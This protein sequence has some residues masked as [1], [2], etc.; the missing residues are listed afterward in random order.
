MADPTGNQKAR[1]VSDAVPRGA[2]EA[3][4]AKWHIQETQ[5]L[6]VG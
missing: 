6:I 2:N 4:A 3:H 1:E 5:L